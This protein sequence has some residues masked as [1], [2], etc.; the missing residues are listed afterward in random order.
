MLTYDADLCDVSSECEMHKDIEGL[1]KK[2][3]LIRVRSFLLQNIFALD[4]ESLLPDESMINI[5]LDYIHT[6]YAKEISLD[7]L[8]KL[9]YVNRTTLTRKFKARTRRTP[10][11]YI[12]HHRLS[13]ACELLTNTKVS[14]G[15]I[16]ET[17]G[18]RYESYF[19]RQFIAKIG[20]TPSEYRKS[21]GFEILGTNES[22]IVEEF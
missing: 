8:C 9:V 15:K 19:T 12:L 22:R 1:I 10:I 2:H 13:I 21:D 7:Y 11:D 14:I 17:V 3:G 5:A 4:S 16:A 6:N 20:M 18:F